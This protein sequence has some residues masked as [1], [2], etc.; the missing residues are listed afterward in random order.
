VAMV[1]F[2]RKWTSTTSLQKLAPVETSPGPSITSDEQIASYV[3]NSAGA[4]EGHSCGTAAM[5][6]RK[7][8]GV[9]SPELLVYGVTGLSVGDVSIIPMIPATHTCATVYAIAEKVSGMLYLEGG[10]LTR[11]LRQLI[12][13]KQ[14]RSE[15]EA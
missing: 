4:T 8:G 5:M 2:H 10:G 12:L 9:V 3:A 6:P 15:R 14:E 1:R 7:L 13:L 11:I